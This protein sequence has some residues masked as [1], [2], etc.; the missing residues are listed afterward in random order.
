MSRSS[1][2][3]SLALAAMAAAIGFVSPASAQAE[4]ADPRAGLPASYRG[5]AS[6]VAA[7]VDDK[8][9]TTYDVQ[10]RVRLMVLSSGGRITNQMLPQ[11]QRQALR[12]LVQEQLKLTEAKE[13]D[14]EPEPGEV[15]SELR[16]MAQQGGVS[17]ETFAQTLKADGVS[18]DALRQQV[19]TS[20][21]WPRLVQGKYGKRIR[22]SDDEIEAT[23][24]RMREDATQDQILLSEICIPVPSQDQ[25][26]AYY[27]GSLQLLE[28]LRKGVPFAVI[29]QQFSGCTTSAAGGDMGWIRAGELAPE[30]DS[31]IRDLPPGSVTNPIPSEGAFMILAV[32][33]RR[34]AVAPG[35]KSW[36]LAYASAPTSM[37][38]AAARAALAK[39]ATADACGGRK[40]RQDLGPNVGV[41]LLERTPIDALDPRF[42]GAIEDLN[43]G[44]MSAVLEADGAYHVAYVCDL[45]EGLGLP[46]RESI[47]G[48]IYSRQLERIAQ[49]YLRDIERKS[50]VDIRMRD[51]APRADG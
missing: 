31:V 34:T 8:V 14:L 9:I 19:T 28:Q 49:Q 26:Q 24:G 17:F 45:D 15:D 33:D 30:L 35:A 37:G 21:I 4:K 40:V 36:T 46:N 39:L 1:F 20:I 7:V 50:S 51:R 42:Q 6:A 29:A 12:D 18:I 11:I 47:R 48:R 22:V 41:A 5:P 16:G 44:D 43:R 13:F 10:Q 3:T 25:A 32:R 38:D 2:K 27:D 23:L